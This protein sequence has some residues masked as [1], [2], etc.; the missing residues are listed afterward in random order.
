MV[1]PGAEQIVRHLSESRGFPCYKLFF[2]RQQRQGHTQQ[3]QQQQQQQQVRIISLQGRAD[4]N[5]EK[6]IKVDFSHRPREYTA[7]TRTVV[8]VSFGAGEH[9]WRT[10]FFL[11]AIFFPFNGKSRFGIGSNPCVAGVK[12]SPIEPSISY[13]T[14]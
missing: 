12:N 6:L 10:L 9:A 2:F 14:S 8:V 5:T 13:C 4:T 1:Q 7:H 11:T 3:Q